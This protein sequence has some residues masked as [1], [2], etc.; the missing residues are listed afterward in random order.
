[1]FNK[2]ILIGRLTADP[3]LKQT[4]S[5]TYV[6]NFQIAVDR[7]FRGPDGERKT[8][9]ITIVCWQRTAEFVAKYFHKG[10]PIGIDGNIQTRNYEDKQGNKRTAFEVVADNAFFVGGK[11]NN[12]GG[13]YAPA[14]TFAPPAAPMSPAPAAPVAYSSG[15]PSDFEEVETDN[16]LPF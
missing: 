9:F 12:S 10:D 6:V 5:G 1:M 16:D 8:D 3:E 2:A 4:N 13:S 15:A 7:R 11:T 14:Q